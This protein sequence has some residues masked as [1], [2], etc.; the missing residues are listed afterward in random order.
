MHEP[1][2]V[3][4]DQDR[5]IRMILDHPAAELGCRD[6]AGELRRVERLRQ[7]DVEGP[8]TGWNVVK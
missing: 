6:Q 8:G 3:T 2:D 1:G 5:G 4:F 7:Q